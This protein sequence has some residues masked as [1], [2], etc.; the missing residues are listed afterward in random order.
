M[1][2][3]LT[4]TEVVRLM[5]AATGVPPSS[6]EEFED[7]AGG[8]M[9]GD[10][11]SIAANPFFKLH[12]VQR[13]ADFNGEPVEDAAFFLALSHHAKDLIVVCGRHREVKNT[14]VVHLSGKVHAMRNAPKILEEIR[15]PEYD[16]LDLHR[17]FIIQE[18][19]GNGQHDEL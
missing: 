4:T 5:S 15:L 3:L 16:T 13:P 10:D 19:L 18:D 17:A 6:A 1:K 7:V 9:R 12:R 8:V 11:T 14:W 2:A